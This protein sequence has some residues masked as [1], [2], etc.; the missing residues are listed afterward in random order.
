MAIFHLDENTIV[1]IVPSSPKYLKNVKVFC[2]KKPRDEEQG[3]ES[4]QSTLYY[5]V[6]SLLQFHVVDEYGNTIHHLDSKEGVG[7]AISFPDKNVSLYSR[8]WMMRRGTIFLTF[9]PKLVG[10][11]QM[12]VRFV[13][14]KD[15]MTGQSLTCSHQIRINIIYPPCSPPLTL[16]HLD[17]NLGKRTAGEEFIFEVKPY[18]IFGNPVLHESEEMCKVT[19]QASSSKTEQLP[20][21]QIITSRRFALS[22]CLKVAGHKRMKLSV[23]SASSS[24]S[25][26]VYVEVLP[27]V[28]HHLNDV[29]FTTTGAVDKNFSAGSTVMYRNQWSFLEAVLVDCY[30]NVIQDLN[31][32]YNF[33]LHLSDDEGKMKYKKVEFLQGVRT[34]VIINKTG[35]HK[36]LVT[37]TCKSNQD[38]AEY[39]LEDV[40]IEVHDP[41]LSLA[42]STFHDG[43]TVVAGEEI[44]VEIHLVDVF[45]CPLP[46]DTTTDYKL[47]AFISEPNENSETV[48]VKEVKLQNSVIYVS[49]VLTRA[50][51]R[52][53]IVSDKNNK[54]RVINM[55]VDPDLT[56]LHWELTGLK[57]T[58]YRRENFVLTVRL[59]DRFNNEVPVHSLGYVP[60]LAKMSGPDGLECTLKSTGLHKVTFH[61]RFTITGQYDIRLTDHEGNALGGA[62][63]LITVTDAPLDRHR[64]S[65]RWIPEYDDI[66][67]HP[68]FPEDESFRCRLELWDILGH[69]Y[70]KIVA[71]DCIKVKNGNLEVIDTEV[72][73][74]DSKIGSYNIVVESTPCSQYW[75]YVNGV[76]IE[77]SIALPD[78]QEFERYDDDNKCRLH[79]IN[80]AFVIDCYEAK[81]KDIRGEDY[82]NLINIKRVCNLSSNINVEDFEDF[83]RVELPLEEIMY[84]VRGN[85][86]LKCSTEEI[87]AKLQKCRNILLRLLRAIY[88]RQ[89]AFELDNDREIWKKMARENYR[90]IEEGENIDRNIPR[91]CREIKEKYAA[92]MG[93]YHDAACVEI[94]EFFNTGRDHSE[95]DLHGLLVVDEKKLR[96]YERLLRFRGHLSSAEVD[97]KIREE[98]EHGNEA[99]RYYTF[100]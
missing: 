99:I 10:K 58:A 97:R 85:Q 47:T 78:C 6:S 75:C 81:K 73:R 18:D 86:K 40:L 87:T 15:D 20:V 17:D 100:E 67:D 82:C 22:V 45:G 25:R 52:Q 24:S 88:Y 31:N 59:C 44:R 9:L 80:N 13:Y 8:E 62:S 51:S 48:V 5:G 57:E 46:A 14:K 66:P 70:D 32:D 98:R 37:L 92:L 60:K 21:R 95:I 41:P 19:M 3:A 89:E 64:S 77:D 12:V 53:V 33:S 96:E 61:C 65:I 29:K 27:S 93:R 49:V 69:K 43:K 94:F 36:L 74:D 71:S 7:V 68:V 90:R 55:H 16:K 91:F 38:K 1:D 28:P 35:K 34:K 83:A 84:K 4:I 2:N 54:A 39:H 11:L 42:L 50:G 76:K 30:D 56:D 79:I 26:N 23:N 72:T 63:V